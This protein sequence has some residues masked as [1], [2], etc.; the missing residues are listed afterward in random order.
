[1]TDTSPSSQSVTETSP[2]VTGTGARL[3]WDLKVHCGKTSQIAGNRD[4]WEGC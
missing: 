4:S 1:M 3:S 2:G